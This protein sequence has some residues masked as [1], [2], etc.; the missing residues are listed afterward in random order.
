MS[1]YG[2]KPLGGLT[3]K[4]NNIAEFNPD[5]HKGHKVLVKGV[6]GRLA[7]GDRINVTLM[8]TVSASCGT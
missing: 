2:G 8:E 5:S 3:F 7:T 1:A 6:L 4:L